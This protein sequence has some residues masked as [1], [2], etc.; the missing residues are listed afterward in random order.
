[1]VI[2]RVLTDTFINCVFIT[3]YTNDYEIACRHLRV[4]EY[5]AY[6]RGVEIDEGRREI[7][8]RNS[9]RMKDKETVR[10]GYR[11]KEGER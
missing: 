6:K 9:G 10:A 4:C 8:K 7:E 5:H 3:L 2:V 1:M 11:D